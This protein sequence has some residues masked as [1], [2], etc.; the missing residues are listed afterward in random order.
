M[1]EWRVWRPSGCLS[2][3]S[4][5]PINSI[6]WELHLVAATSDDEKWILWQDLC[7]QK[8]RSAKSSRFSNSQ[9]TISCA[10]AAQVAALQQL[11]GR[12]FF[13][14]HVT[15]AAHGLNQALGVAIFK[16]GTQISDVDFDD[17]R[18]TDEVIAP[19][20]VENEFAG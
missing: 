14:K 12:L 5:K 6:A 10:L 17:V 13:A 20:F 19:Y 16:F 11:S 1:H 8:K 7:G 3:G 4:P 9:W 18:F 2:G 15:F